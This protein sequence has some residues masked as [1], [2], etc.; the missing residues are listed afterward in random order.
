MD[1]QLFEWIAKLPLKRLEEPALPTFSV[2]PQ[3]F[4][5]SVSPT[6]C[7][8]RDSVHYRWV[9]CYRLSIVLLRVR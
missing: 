4:R 6:G 7:R 3:S 2:G 5:F 8:E 1:E 9:R